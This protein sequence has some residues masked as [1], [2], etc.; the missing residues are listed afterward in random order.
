M[1]KL[2]AALAVA[3]A[4]IAA[5]AFADTMQNTYGNTIVVTYPSGAEA[6][7][8]FNEDG[9][10]TGTAPGG[11]TT[12]GRWTAEGEQLCLIPPSGQAPSCTTIQ[13]GKNV[14]DAWT[15]LGSDGSEIN[16]ELR[17]GR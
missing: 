15:Q 8:F 9:T 3:V 10:F 13:A 6:R 1:K 5:P 7:Y 11:S 17:A 2:A 14:G 12:A 16:V 4:L